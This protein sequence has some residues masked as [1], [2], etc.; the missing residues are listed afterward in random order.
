MLKLINNV[1]IKDLLNVL[2][3]IIISIS[4]VYFLFVKLD[5]K[6]IANILRS[7][8]IR[9]F[10]II[11]VIYIISVFISA[12]KWWIISPSGTVLC[13]FKT[14]ICSRFYALV[15]PG[16]LFGEVSKVTILNGKNGNAANV[17]MSVLLDKII[18]TVS[19][20]ILGVLGVLLT[21]S[22]IPRFL[23]IIIIL[24]F[25]V[26]VFIIIYVFFLYKSLLI[27]KYIELFGTKFLNLV[28][29]DK[30]KNIVNYAEDIFS[31]VHILFISI[32]VGIFYQLL[33]AFFFEIIGVYYNINVSL[34]DWFWINTILT[35]ALLIPISFAGIGIREGTLITF[36]GLVGISG[37]QG[38]VV[39]LV[40]FTVQLLEGI[41]GGMIILIGKYREL[42]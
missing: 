18:G 39:S 9:Q 35:L 41:F 30:V 21:D 37:E 14:L 17:A 11:C 6:V 22:E 38:M 2:W 36:L 12:V 1:R 34:F 27:Y 29:I 15:L 31:H 23:N 10:L 20:L 19:L 33:N 3:K 24:C 16:Q 28:W 25:L 32:L 7:I 5:Y 4:I 40:L 26:S 8:S 42:N 13:Y